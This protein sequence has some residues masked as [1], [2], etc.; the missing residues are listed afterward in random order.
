MVLSFIVTLLSA[1]TTLTVNIGAQATE[2]DPQSVVRLDKSTRRGWLGVSIQ[3]LTPKLAKAMGAK[4]QEGALV[5]EVERKSP[6]DSAGIQEEDVIVEF[7]GRKIYDADDLR[8]SVGR[9]KP[10]TT[11]SVIVD[12]KGTTKTLKLTVG[13]NPA[14]IARAFSFNMPGPHVFSFGTSRAIGAELRE[15][16]DQLAEY[17]QVPDSKGVLVESVEKGSA[18][19]KADMKAGDVVIKIGGERVNEMSDVWE[20]LEDYE[21]GEKVDFEVIRKGASRKL[22][23]EIEEEGEE[24]HWYQFRTRPRGHLFD[25]D[26]GHDLRFELE[27]IP[28]IHIEKIRPELDMLKFDMHRL[29]NELRFKFDNDFPE[30][31]L[32]RR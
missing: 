2:F 13:K 21:E 14:R 9:T 29:R 32:K 7:D 24:G 11:V 27:K 28:R 16:N 20:A 23:V 1:I 10:G 22:T 31:D 19:E 6:A 5:S 12:R 4:V 17:F 15:L 30:F 3:D 25:R 26:F 8:K 18:A